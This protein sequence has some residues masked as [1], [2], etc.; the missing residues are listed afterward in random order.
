MKVRIKKKNKDGVVRLESSGAVKEIIIN[1]DFLKPKDAY[2]SVCFKGKESSGIIDLSVLEI[3][4]L[5]REVHKK[6]N[7][8][9]DVKMMKFNKE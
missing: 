7:L 5:N 3:E 2:V 8:L 4:E 9:G 6:K 1:E